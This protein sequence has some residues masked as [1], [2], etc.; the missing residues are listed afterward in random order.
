MRGRVIARMLVGNRRL[1]SAV[2]HLRG[3]VPRKLLRSCESPLRAVC[4]QR[5]VRQHSVHS[6]RQDRHVIR[7]D[8]QSRV[9]KYFWQGATVRRDDGYAG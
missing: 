2:E 3:T 8:E 4:G 7:I 9:S 6:G 1:I 5:L